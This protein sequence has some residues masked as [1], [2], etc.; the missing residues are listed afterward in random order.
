MC[1]IDVAHRH[2]V[3][4]IHKSLTHWILHY[5]GTDA[6]KARARVL[7]CGCGWRRVVDALAADLGCLLCCL[8]TAVDGGGDGLGSHHAAR[9]KLSAVKTSRYEAGQV[10]LVH[11]LDSPVRCQMNRWRPPPRHGDEVH[12]HEVV[13]RS[14]LASRNVVGG[15]GADLHATCTLSAYYRSRWHDLNT[16]SSGCCQK[17]GV[18]MLAQICNPNTGAG[19]CQGNGIAIGTIVIGAEYCVFARH[20]A[21]AIDIGAHCTAQ[22]DAR[23]VVTCKKKGSL[24][25]A[26]GHHNTLGT[27]YVHALAG[28]APRCIRH[29]GCTAF[30]HADGVAVVQA[31][32]ARPVQQGDLAGV[33][34]VCQRLLEPMRLCTVYRVVE[35]RAAPFKVLLDQ[36]YVQPRTCRAQR[37]GQTC[38]AG[39]DDEYIRKSMAPVIAVRVWQLRCLPQSR[40]FADEVLVEHPR[41]AGWPHERLVIEPRHK[42]RGKQV[43]DRHQVELHR[44]PGVLSRGDQTRM[45][46]DDCGGNIGFPTVAASDGQECIR[47][48]YASGHDAA[49]PVVF[50]GACH[51]M[52][53]MRQKS[54]RDCVTG[55]TGQ[56]FSIEAEACLL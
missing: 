22:H 12:W 23:A 34:Q 19:L 38:R 27:Q 20:N 56:G 48:F 2:I 36:C 26:A 15:E 33:L 3:L 17:C 41:L 44:G 47:L 51:Q 11:R 24:Q 7:R 9:T 5:D 46:L 31:K 35:Q 25:C 6:H 45:C 16:R 32:R 55:V 18:N 10:T 21:V 40:S 30:D 52:F 43:V 1:Q 13:L 29:A 39:A 4:E 8:P 50:E 54:G 14:C 42:D 28:H 49:R 53:A 37:S